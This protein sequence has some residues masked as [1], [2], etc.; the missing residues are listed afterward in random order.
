MTNR[1]IAL[2]GALAPIL[3]LSASPASAAKHAFDDL[4]AEE[5]AAAVKIVRD[6][7]KFSSDVRFPV[8]KR[9]EP[10]KGDWLSGKAKD[11]RQ[12][13]VAVFDF[14]SSLM[15]ELTLDLKAKQLLSKKDLP[16][17]K[18]PLLLEEYD[19]ARQIAKADPRWQQAMKKRGFANLD[20]VFLDIWA[21]GLI[22]PEE[23]KP[24]QRLLRG[25][26][27]KKEGK[28][29][30]GR[31]IDGV[32]VTVDL[33]QKK[34]VSVWDIEMPPVAA[35]SKQFGVDQQ[36][37]LDPPLARLES[38]MPDGPSFKIDGQEISWNH[39][40]FRY[41]MDP[42]Q[43]LQLFHVRYVDEGQERSVIYK[44]SLADM[45][46]PYGIPEKTWS[47]RAA[48]DVGEYGLGKTL[49]PLVA[50]QDVP[51]HAAL[52]DTP[53]AD[54]LG[55]EAQVIK[56][57]AIYERDAG[58]LWKHR[59]A[60]NGDTDLRHA[61]QLVVTFMTTIGNYDYGINYI[62]GLDGSIR[63]ETQL[64]G[65]LLA[66]GTAMERNPCDAGCE[67]LAEKYILTPQHQHFFNFR[68]DFDI[69]GAKGNRAAE[70][71]VHAIPKGP[72]NP[73]G[74]AFE[75]VNTMLTREKNSARDVDFKSARKWK[76]YNTDSR[77]ALNHPRGYA[78]FPEETAFSYMHPSN[79]IR[80]RA[81]FVE[82]QAWFTAFKDDESSAAH[83]YPTTA[84]AGAG[85][86]KYISNNESL[87]GADVVMWYT[88]GVTHIPH[89]EE[90]PIMN[91]HRTGFTIQPMNFFSQ[92]P[93]IGVRE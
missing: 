24:G 69:D 88:F 47:F 20:D 42:M 4:S 30:Y 74:N 55:G 91:T 31:P 82:H 72:E 86:P 5:I 59:N 66:K 93:A 73:D 52:L 27:Y 56:G 49:H 84:P 41:S 33:S 57:A 67:P 37:K 90:W 61:R 10:K 38:K 62:F 35:G 2:F 34:V 58:I 9:Q 45:L 87:N 44:L 22:R 8:V 80:Q 70:T 81:R 23:N 83:P 11:Q 32:I 54:D 28:N 14:K 19:R 60:E 75:L 39:W 53:V 15:S 21:P 6:T 13:Y 7:G 50:G 29:V 64:T 68:I 63:V 65:I 76:V 1:T 16:G 25:V 92:N 78:L 51:M 46:V 85:L 77:N 40:K 71:N 48:F 18:P 12:A 17:I 3:L 36:T 89:P 79:Q 43:G 26:S